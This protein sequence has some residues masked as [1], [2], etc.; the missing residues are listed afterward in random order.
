MNVSKENVASNNL[1][2]ELNEKRALNGNLEFQ[3]NINNEMQNEFQNNLENNIQNNN[4]IV[5]EELN[6]NNE[7]VLIYENNEIQS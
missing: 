1:T 7:E 4:E 2:N 3:N 5:N 6:N